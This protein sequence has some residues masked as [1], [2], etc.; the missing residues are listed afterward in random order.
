LPEIAK[1]LCK[2]FFHTSKVDQPRKL[3]VWLRRKSPNSFLIRHFLFDEKRK[4]SL[5]IS[6]Q[7]ILYFN[8]PAYIIC[9]IWIFQFSIF[10]QFQVL[11]IEKMQSKII[12]IAFMV[13]NEALYT[14][15]VTICN[16]IL[17]NF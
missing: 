3:E 17:Y 10:F 2:T 6:Q 12:L 13:N 5:E 15:I 4:M 14:K 16:S 11:K 8:D 1:K 9:K 7:K